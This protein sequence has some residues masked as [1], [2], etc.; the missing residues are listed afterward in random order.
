[1]N[2]SVSDMVDGPGAP[3]P[4]PVTDSKIRRGI[5]LFVMIGAVLFNMLL[6]TAITPVLSTAAK[7]FGSGADAQIIAQLIIT[8]TA[9][10]IMIGGPLSGWLAE[11]I[12]LRT[13]LI[14]A[15]AVYGVAGGSGLF[16]ER[17]TPLLAA[18][19]LQGMAAGGIAISS[20]S[21]LGERF[22]GPARARVFGY[23]GALTAAAGFLTGLGAG[24]LAEAAGWR[25]PFGLYLLAFVMIVLAL[26]GQG[27]PSGYRR[28]AAE[29][30]AAPVPRESLFKLWRLYAMLVPLYAAAFMFFLQLSF[31]LAGDGIG[32]P[33]LQ[34][35]I[36]AAITLANFLGGLVYGRIL[37]RLGT[38]RMF[39]L[40]LG[41]MAAS[42]LVAGLG[43][44]VAAMAAACALSGFG[45]GS[46]VPY[47]T[48]LFISRAPIHLRSRALGFMYSGIYI[49]QFVNPFTV[50]PLRGVI[51]NH[52]AFVVVG[53]LLAVAA[54][55]QGLLPKSVGS[56]AA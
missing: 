52:A 18:R 42:D 2:S 34:S 49:G 30:A 45:G 28:P 32:S 36:F 17:A 39:C 15:L 6:L 38:K 14:S 43:H 7:H 3:V 9:I 26:I 35:K 47:I 23:Q 29:I 8:M 44:G 55:A 12:G 46:L 16:L 41:M 40:I 13:V 10:G 48:N 37:E 20:Y 5:G 19:F 22:Q 50:T 24:Q 53:G 21:M 4:V 33:A 25:A 31:L 56:E 1:M 51:G 27:I 54:L 11:R